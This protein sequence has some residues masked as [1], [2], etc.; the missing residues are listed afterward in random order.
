MAPNGVPCCDISDG[1]RTDYDVQSG[2]YWVPTEGQWT[3][4]PEGAIIRG[5]GIR[6]ATPWSGTFTTAAPSS[7]ASC[8]RMESSLM[9]FV[10]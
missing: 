9:D 7:A 6:S 4:V 8:R 10:G 5:Q 2:A 3:E 1:H